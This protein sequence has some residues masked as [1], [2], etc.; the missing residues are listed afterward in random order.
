MAILHQ[1]A[2][3]KFARCGYPAIVVFYQRGRAKGVCRVA[4]ST[5]TALNANK[6]ARATIETVALVVISD[7][8]LLWPFEFGLWAYCR[9]VAEAD[10]FIPL[11][12]NKGT[13]DLIRT[14]IKVPDM[15]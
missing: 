8:F 11:E 3:E 6:K 15:V 7:A 1:Y 2:L 10:T 13:S 12:E 9:T 14:T 4:G 5:K